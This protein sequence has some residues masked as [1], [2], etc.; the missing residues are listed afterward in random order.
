VKI[1]KIWHSQ[2]QQNTLLENAKKS[3]NVKFC[4]LHWWQTAC[5][6]GS[7]SIGMVGVAMDLDGMGQHAVTLPPNATAIPCHPNPL[8]PSWYA[9]SLIYLPSQWHCCCGELPII[10]QIFLGIPIISQVVLTIPHHSLHF[11]P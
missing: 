8:P 9:A 4:Q 5:Y 11:P 6:W 1:S 2:W 10:E 7:N 3:G